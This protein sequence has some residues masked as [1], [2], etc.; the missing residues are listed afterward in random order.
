MKQSRRAPAI[1]AFLRGEKSNDKRGT[2]RIANRLL[3]RVRDFA[4]IRGDGII[5]DE[6]ADE[7]LTALQVDSEGLDVLDRKILEMMIDGFDG[8]PVGLDTLCSSIGE[9]KET[10][11]MMYEPFLLQ[12]GFI[13]R[14]PRGRMATKKAYQHLNKELPE[15]HAS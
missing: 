3:K 5:T 14:T 13:Q 10:I 9:E 6:A 11:E 12:T 4:Q 15:R 2:P 1:I 8:G 7:A